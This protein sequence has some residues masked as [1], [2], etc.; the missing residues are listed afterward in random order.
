M[1]SRFFDRLRFFSTV[2]VFCFLV[3]VFGGCDNKKA[4]TDN[5]PVP[6]VTYLEVNTTRVTLTREL[7]GRTSPHIISDV[8]PQVSGIIQERFFTEGAHVEKGEVL[9][10]IDP[11][12]YQAAYDSAQAALKE[13]EA[14]EI[15]ARHLEERY[16]KLI[17]TNAVSQQ[18]YDDAKVALLE[19]RARI[20]SARASLETARINLAYTRITAPVSGFIGRSF[21]TP[22]ALVTQNQETPLARV[23]QLDP[24]YVDITR[25]STDVFR[26]QQ[27]LESGKLIS[28][29]KNAMNVLLKLEDGTYLSQK[30]TSCSGKNSGDNG[31]RPSGDTHVPIR[32]ELKFSEVM[33]EPSTDMVTLRAL[34]PNPNGRLLPG[35]YVRAVIEEGIREGAIL[36]P[37]KTVTRDARGI[38][39]VWV[40]VP[41]P[42][43]P[44]KELYTLQSRVITLDR[45]IGNQWLVLDGLDQGTRL[46]VEGGMHVRSGQIVRGMPETAAIKIKKPISALPALH[47]PGTQ[48]FSDQP[49]PKNVI[50]V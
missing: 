46:L 7:P 30:N 18:E 13:A 10:Q 27:D 43:D 12:L 1:N 16:G 4:R 31:S 25:S 19:A 5:G 26:V 49:C 47:P 41:V 40:L 20:S 32:G 38:A 17:K 42:D 35:L 6:T 33:V 2:L 21:V 23:Q 15:S 36:I 45:P 44:E 3:P 39:S 8:R 22:G 11:S 37:Q 34:F 29:G 24:I 9:Y 14:R 48:P 50:S 28:S